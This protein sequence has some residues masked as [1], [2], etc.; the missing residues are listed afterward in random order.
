MLKYPLFGHAIEIAVLSRSSPRRAPEN[1][2]VTPAMVRPSRTDL[3]VVGTFNPAVI[4]H[5]D[6]IIL[7][8]RVAEAPPASD[9]DVVAPI[10]DHRSG[11]LDI[12]KWTRGSTGV[13]T[14]DPRVTVVD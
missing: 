4:R 6:E 14:S 9:G 5:G 13:D 8:L 11:Q 2:I 10:Y 7:L 12:K 3:E 1:P